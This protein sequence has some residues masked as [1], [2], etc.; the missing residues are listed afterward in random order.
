VIQCVSRCAK[1]LLELETKTD[2]LNVIIMTAVATA[3]NT[4]EEAMRVRITREIKQKK[5][6]L[7]YLISLEDS[8]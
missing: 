8:I 4:I 3:Q 2:V 5:Y 7:S 1:I 6:K